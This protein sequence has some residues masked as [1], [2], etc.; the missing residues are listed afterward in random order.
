M[1]DP[2]TDLYDFE[3]IL[4]DATATVFKAGGFTAGNALTV[5]SDPAFQKERPRVEIVFKVNGGVIPLRYFVM[6][7]T[8]L[9]QSAFRGTLT[10]YAISDADKPGKLDHSIFRAKVRNFCATLGNRLNGGALTKHKVQQIVDGDTA[11]GT[12]TQDNLYQS[13]L[14]FDVDFSLQTDAL[15]AIT[16]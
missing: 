4:A 16:T 3:N 9:R 13:T 15:T 11:Q 6:P 5:S 1:S 12:R 10:I 7:D 2:V 14:N 8:T